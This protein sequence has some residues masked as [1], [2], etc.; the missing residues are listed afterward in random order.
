MIE[1]NR[2]NIVCPNENH[3]HDIIKF[4]KENESFLKP[5]EP[6]RPAYFFSQKYWQE[7]IEKIE[8]CNKSNNCLRVLLINKKTKS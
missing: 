7:N 4:Y 5:W 6:N 3:I 8:K 2:L 1:T